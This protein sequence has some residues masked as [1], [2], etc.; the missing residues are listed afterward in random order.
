MTRKIGLRA[1]AGQ[2]VAIIAGGVSALLLAVALLLV[3]APGNPALIALSAITG[4]SVALAATA[5]LRARR[6]EAQAAKL[7]GDLDIVS[8]PAMAAK[9]AK[10]DARLA[11]SV[12]E[13]TAEIGL[14]GGI[15]RDL[16]NAVA[17][18]DRD[19]AS[20]RG[21]IGRSAPP[22]GP[23][24]DTRRSRARAGAPAGRDPRRQAGPRRAGARAGSPGRRHPRC[25]RG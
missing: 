14:M 13:I 17:A 24:A 20:V 21:G 9:E 15:L 22:R 4:A 18:H 12:D 1:G 16:A 5:L 10:P 11:D 3:L 8:P 23:R 2:S 6:L 7:S 25:F 19:L